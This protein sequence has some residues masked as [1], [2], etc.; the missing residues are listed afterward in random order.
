V[1]WPLSSP[2]NKEN[3]FLVGVLNLPSKLWPLFRL[4]KKVDETCYAKAAAET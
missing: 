2:Q 1:V 3:G 4:S